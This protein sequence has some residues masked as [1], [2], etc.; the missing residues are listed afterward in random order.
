[1]IDVR[2][3][4]QASR[5]HFG[6]QPVHGILWTGNCSVPWS[7]HLPPSRVLRQ[8]ITAVKVQSPADRD[9]TMSSPGGSLFR[10][11]LAEQRD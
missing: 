7:I 9:I 6:L 11:Q 2:E 10:K 1:M 3:Y 8:D 5:L 4:G